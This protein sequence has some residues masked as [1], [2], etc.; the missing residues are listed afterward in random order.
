MPS[1]GQ[2]VT[3]PPWC[4]L[5]LTVGLE[6]K[7]S[8]GW[9]FLPV[10]WDKKILD[11]NSNLQSETFTNSLKCPMG[12]GVPFPS[13]SFFLRSFHTWSLNY[14]HVRRRQPPFGFANVANL[15]R[16]GV[17]GERVNSNS[18]HRVSIP[19]WLKSIEWF[20]R[21]SGSGYCAWHAWHVAFVSCR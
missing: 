5:I 6:L 19:A 14:G 3:D 11:T 16:V 7:W 21:D 17:V 15:K 8:N 18:N 4:S 2:F 13:L 20:G 1:V 9:G 10:N 12:M